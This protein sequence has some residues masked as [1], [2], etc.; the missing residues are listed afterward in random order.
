[1]SA[2]YHTMEQRSQA[3]FEIRLGRPTA[4]E[5]SNIVTPGGADGKKAKPSESA[6]KYAHRL[7]AEMMIGHILE[8]EDYQSQFMLRGQELED[9]AI[10]AYEMVADIET[11]PGGF[12]T[13]ERKR[14][15][16]SPD[17]LVGENRLLEMK[18]PAAHTHVRYLLDPDSIRAEKRP[19]AQ[20]Q[21]L[22][23]ERDSVDLVSFHPEMPIAIVQ[24]GRDEAYLGLLQAAL[25]TFC[26]QLALMREKL[27]REY[28][29]FP[30]IGAKVAT[31]ADEYNGMGVSEVDIPALIKSGAIQPRA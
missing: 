27:E 20:G 12:V 24:V 10:R 11:A 2:I 30:E 26:E 21:L 15:G 8:D 22:V 9:K 23:C 13:D 6:P 28:G 18:C 1:M 16:C 17:R 14:Y 5:F 3:W 29:P 4:S 31:T 19:Q 25:D 7:L